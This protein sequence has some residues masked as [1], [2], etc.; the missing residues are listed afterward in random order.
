MKILSIALSVALVIMS[1]M[2]INLKRQYQ[3]QEATGQALQ[4]TAET[5]QQT[6]EALQREDIQGLIAHVERVMRREIVYERGTNPLWRYSAGNSRTEELDRVEVDLRIVGITLD[7]DRGEI[8]A[9]YSIQWFDSSGRTLY[10]VSLLSRPTWPAIWTLERQGE[11][12]V[13]V[14]VYEPT[15]QGPT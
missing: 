7:G 4:Q 14:E 9:I 12:W 1:V 10:G 6:V 3:A 11:D 8:R 5:L 15:K 2:L 13:I